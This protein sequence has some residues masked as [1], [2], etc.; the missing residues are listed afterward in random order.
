MSPA[1]ISTDR[2]TAALLAGDLADRGGLA[3]PVDAD[4]QPHVR[5]PGDAVVEVQLAIGPAE[6]LGHVGLERIEQRRRL[7]DLLGLDPRLEVVDQGV[8]HGDADVGAQQ[9]LLELV[10][11]V[12]G[13]RAAVPSTPANAPVNADRAFAIRS[14]SEAGLTGSTTGASSRTGAPS[15]AGS[16]STATSLGLGSADAAAAR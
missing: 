11:G 12:V 15:T 6:A 1:A 13:D 5:A 16:S 2:P 10:P 14:R 4:E 9:R 7:G 3:H 8:G